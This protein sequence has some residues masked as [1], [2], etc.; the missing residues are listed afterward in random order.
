MLA[1]PRRL[2]AT[3]LLAGSVGVAC[4]QAAPAA[5]PPPRTAVCV[6]CHGQ[7]GM[8]AAPDTPHIAAQPEIY[9][10]AQ[11]KA[12]RSGARK[13]EV[14]NVIARSLSDED[15]AALAEWYSRVKIEVRA[16]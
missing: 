9:L 7:L 6:T 12:F 4:A 16:P 14:M 15:I 5:Q 10:V 1:L 8:G 13:H 2:G 3:L 11:L